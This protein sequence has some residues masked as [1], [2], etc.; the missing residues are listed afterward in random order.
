ML[1]IKDSDQ[2]AAWLTR[3]SAWCTYWNKFL[4]EKTKIDG[5]Y[6]LTHERLVK[7]KNSLDVLIRKGTLFTYLDPELILE[8]TVPA[9][10]NKI[11]GAVNAPLRQMLR[12]HRG[13]SLIRRIKAIF[14]WCYMHTEDPLSASEVLKV[15]PT[16]QDID[17]YY[18]GLSE[19]QQLH[20]SIPMWGDAVAW[21]E[22]HNSAPYR[23][24]WD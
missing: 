17:K 23:M 18:R 8:G 2:A 11:E 3:Y 15:M 22:F 1:H 24:D 12:D 20:D 21:S 9:T 13:L 19:P 14:W 6:V 4:E 10:N 7:A 5:R 16:D